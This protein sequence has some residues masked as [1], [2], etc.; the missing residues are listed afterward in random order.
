MRPSHIGL[1]N[2]GWIAFGSRSPDAS[3]GFH[4]NSSC[5]RAA[6]VCRK[7]EEFQCEKGCCFLAK[8]PAK[9]LSDRDSS[10]S[11]LLCEDDGETRFG[12]NGAAYMRHSF[13]RR[14]MAERYLEVLEHGAEG[15]ENVFEPIQATAA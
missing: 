9:L 8:I 13:S 2:R 1:T 10:S 14:A 7:D 6:Y 11:L 5:A 15:D 3:T 12:A 4:S